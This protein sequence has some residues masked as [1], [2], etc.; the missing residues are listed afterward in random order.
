VAVECCFSDA[1]NETVGALLLNPE[2]RKRMA[3]TATGE[4]FWSL[5]KRLHLIVAFARDAGQIF[6]VVRNLFL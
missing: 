2:A 5:L 6:E 4:K 1:T 3:G